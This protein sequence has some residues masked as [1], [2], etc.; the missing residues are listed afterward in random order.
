MPRTALFQW[1]TDRYPT[2][3]IHRSA[4]ARQCYRLL[5]ALARP[6]GRI[7]LRSGAYRVGF[8]AGPGP[9]GLDIAREIALSGPWEPF[10][11]EVFCSRLRPGMRV[12]D[13]GANIGHYT[14]IAAPRVGPLGHVH[15]FEPEPDLHR[16]LLANIAANGLGNVTPHRAA[17]GE[18]EGFSE[19]FA[20]PLNR[21]A[22]SFS[23]RNVTAGADPIRVKTATLDAL[24]NRI[25]LDPPVH[26]IKMDTQGAEG[27]ILRGGMNTL[28]RFKPVLVMEF[29][30]HGLKNCGDSAEA[31]LSLLSGLGYRLREINERE[32]S[33][34]DTTA[35]RLLAAYPDTVDYGFTNLLATAD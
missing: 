8:E 16:E 33:L 19:M 23:R 34:Q 11:T 3:A 4:L 9:A 14:L 31:V 7:V 27:A 26:L 24:T 29:W 10:E 5:L 28:R 25:G 2:P 35:E 20:H 1:I 32:Q 21:G 6:K 12:Y 17:C 15:A 22:H 13:I 30:P 18:R